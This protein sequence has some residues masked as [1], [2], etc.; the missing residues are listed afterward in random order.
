MIKHNAWNVDDGPVAINR[1]TWRDRLRWV[2]PLVCAPGE[3][4]ETRLR[5]VLLVVAS[6]LVVPAGLFWGA[7][8]WIFDERTVALFPF[9]YSGL[10]LLDLLILYRLRRYE[11]FRTIQQFLILALPIAFHLALGGF[12][13]SSAAILW[14]F[15]A[16]LMALL[17]GGSREAIYW[18]IAYVSAVVITAALQPSV[19]IDNALPPWL[20]LIFFALNVVTVSLL[21]FVVLHSFVSDRRKLRELE[22]AA[23]NRELLLRQSQRLAGLG[24]LAAG[25]AHELNNPAAATRRAAGQ[26]RDAFTSL[27]KA[28]I[29]L[30]AATLTPAGR[31]ML[32]SLE[33]QARERASDQ[34]DL[35][36]LTRADL[37]AA[38]EEWLDERGVADPWGLAPALVGLGLDPPALTRLAAVFQGETLGAALTWIASLFPV[39]GL[40]NEI[41][42]GSS[43]ISEIVGALKSY[44]YLGQAPAQEVNLH[45]GIDNTLV[46]LR[47][48]L[49]DGVTVRREYGAD[50]L[51]VPGYGS[52]LNQVWTNLL[53]NAA[54]ALGGKGQV[55][56]RTRHEGGWAVV[57]IE[58]D[59]TGIPEENLPRIFDPFFTTKAPGEG[60]GLGLSTSYGIVA[61]KHKG[62]IRVESQPGCTRFTVKL[63]IEPP[64]SAD[65]AN[66]TSSP[67]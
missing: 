67:Q 48:K 62:E 26:L 56:I 55:I 1:T 13:G 57:E 64:R 46:I 59:G 33:R 25:I 45:E 38:V 20:V 43:R 35:D 22:V 8:Y 3:D 44:T 5:K 6:V 60:T 40:L 54:D 47:N 37:E 21:A 42:Q 7:V 34:S 51:L 4:Q 61:E 30:N 15:L 58:D 16:V 17:F 50:A 39:Y 36:A 18:F 27:E 29:Q 10:T 53:D 11:L 41:G 65:G 14:S 2:E 23:R 9:A 28:H 66:L 12:V 49:K 63:P 31:E 24:T 19:T 52:E 32:Q